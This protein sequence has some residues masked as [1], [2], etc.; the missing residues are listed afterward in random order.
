MQILFLPKN[1]E[2]SNRTVHIVAMAL[3]ELTH[4]TTSDPKSVTSILHIQQL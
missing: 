1:H 3:V 2:S 4:F